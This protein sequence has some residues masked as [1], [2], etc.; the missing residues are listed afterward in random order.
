MTINYE[1]LE[2]IITPQRLEIYRPEGRDIPLTFAE[3][4]KNIRLAEA[5][6][7]SLH[8]FEIVLRNRLEQLL[9]PVRKC[10]M[11]WLEAGAYA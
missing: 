9:Q 5:L 8:V 2:Q 7:P 11:I 6:Y 4:E 1:N 10:C 3:Y